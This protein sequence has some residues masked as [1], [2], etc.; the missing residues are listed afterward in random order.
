[1]Q[2]CFWQVIAGPHGLIYGL[3]TAG[4][5]HYSSS[6]HKWLYKRCVLLSRA[7][8]CELWNL[9]RVRNKKSGP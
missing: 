6:L 3:T 8:G 4:E 2:T 5:L 9:N 1:M 7:K